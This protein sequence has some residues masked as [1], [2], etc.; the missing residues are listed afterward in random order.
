R[1][2]PRVVA[3]RAVDPAAVDEV[4]GRAGFQLDRLLGV[5]EGGVPLME[6]SPDDRSGAVRAGPP[7]LQLQG[8]AQI[9]VGSLPLPELGPAAAAI[10][11]GV[12]G[13]RVEG[14]Q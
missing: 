10:R 8:L 1:D 14:E 7:R 4:A 3:L 2:L 13:I 11:V 6:V 9:L 12:G 5:A